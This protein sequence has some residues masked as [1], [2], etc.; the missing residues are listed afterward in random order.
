MAEPHVLTTLQRKR[1]E[2]STT[3][4]Q[5][6]RRLVEARRD[7]EHVNATIRLFES[8]TAGDGVKVYQDIN[9]LFR[10][11]E[12]SAICKAALA[13][14]G[15]MDTRELSHHVMRVKGFNEVDNE[16]RKAIAYRIVQTMRKQYARG[17]VG[18]A[19]KRGN[20]IVW[21]TAEHTDAR[22]R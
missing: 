21:A 20:V 17:L 13:V 10:R 9:R 3:I 15:P 14:Q 18:L 12:L 8:A 2:I 19:G 5:Y 1:D 16:L 7:L 11:R 22:H 6:E 4:A